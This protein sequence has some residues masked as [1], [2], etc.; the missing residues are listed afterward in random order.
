MEDKFGKT[1]KENEKVLRG[2]LVENWCKA[3]SNC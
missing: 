1:E 3:S 2:S